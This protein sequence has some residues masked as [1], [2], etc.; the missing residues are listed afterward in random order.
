MA[1]RRGRLEL[2]P[3]TRQPSSADQAREAWHGRPVEDVLA[4]LS[5]DSIR[6]LSEREAQRRL[7]RHGP[8]ALH[9]PKPE[10]WW[11]AALEAIREPLQLLL[12][13]VGVAYFLLGEAQDALTIAVV[14][15]VVTAI[16]VVNELRATRAVAALASLAAPAATVIRDGSA[17]R[18]P[19]AS[20][21]PGDLVALAAGQRVPADLRLVETW[22]LRLDESSLTGESVPV[23]KDATALVDGGAELGDHRTMAYAGGLVTAGRAVGMVVA[24]GRG[25][26]LGRIADSIEESRQPPTPLQGAMRELAG[27]LVWVAIGVSVIVPLLGIVVANLPPRTMVLTGLTLAFATIPEELPILVT[28]VLAIGAYRLSREG[29]IV[30]RLAVTETLGSVTVVATDKTGTLT[31]NGMRVV[32]VI[33]DGRP[34]SPAAAAD[35]PIGRRLIE[36]WVIANDA[37]VSR[38]AGAIQFIGDPTEVALLAAAEEAGLHVEDIRR[39]VRAIR[40]HPF[41]DGQKRMSVVVAREGAHVL[42]LKGA[43]EPVLIACVAIRRNGRVEALDEPGRTTLR[44]L[45]DEMAGRG[46]RVLAVAERQL[47]GDDGARSREAAE[48]ETDLTFLGLVGLA[49]PPRP[50]AAAAV[51]SLR[52][53]GIRVLMLTGDHPATAVSIAGQVGIAD[54]AAV[55]GREVDELSDEALAERATTTAVFA[56]IT[57]AH[58]L[59]VIRALRSRGEVVAVTG[60]GVNDG[61]AL[62]EAAIGIAMGQTGSD[63]AREAADIVLADDNLAT[64]VTAIRAGRTI[65]ANLRRAVRFYLAVKVALVAASIAAVLLRLPVPFEPVQIILMELFMDV[66]ASMTFVTEPPEVDVMARPPRDPGGPFMDRTMEWGIL[67]GGLSL[68]AAVLVAYLWASSQGGGLLPAQTA[69]FAA[70]MV[71]HVV[72]AAHMRSERA[73]VARSFLAN[74]AYLVWAAA[75]I[76]VVVLGPTVPFLRERLHLVALPGSDWLV[77]VAAAVILPSWW[78]PW[79][80]WRSHV[81]RGGSHT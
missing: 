71:G 49:D 5:S 73:T 51:R 54:G 43:P 15:V 13:A 38:S 29:A 36:T 12:V 2:D 61:P 25:T 35:T 50:E 44:A 74:R 22:A 46:L 1:R 40:E 8:N 28:M 16:E 41:D 14:I 53:A 78:E 80:R 67:A 37:D 66:G 45:A 64:V 68:G 63:V 62:R 23:V 3:L 47:A 72:L 70:W 77:T 32:E 26:E 18:R 34:S 75:A 11:E 81:D 65:H 76:L 52:T 58:K 9:P 59:R 27:W 42:A 48:V 31:T 60:D 7:D 33:V 55:S 39:S 4:A 19:A 17:A 24:T 57:A 10:P 21:V 79:K 30:R 20:L 6:G 69:A 56:R